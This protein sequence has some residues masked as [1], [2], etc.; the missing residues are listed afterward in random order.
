[1][2]YTL[3]ERVN[4]MKADKNNNL[5]PS[6]DDDLRLRQATFRQLHKIVEVTAVVK[7]G[8]FICVR[9]MLIYF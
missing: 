6:A 2:L 7:P 9:L 8:K 5:S 4:Q 3:S 1:M